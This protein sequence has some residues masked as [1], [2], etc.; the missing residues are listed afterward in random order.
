M[1]LRK[2]FCVLA[3]APVLLTGCGG[4]SGKDP[5]AWTDEVCGALAGFSTTVSS[6]PAVDQND[7]EAVKAGLSTFFASTSAALKEAI[8]GL[9]AAG[10]APVKGGDEYVTRLTETLT[11]IDTSFTATSG[12]IGQ[13]D[14]SSPEAFATALTTELAPLQ[15][16]ENIADPTRGLED[17]QELGAAADKA[18]NCQKLRTG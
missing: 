17:A 15:E 16:L 11:R 5:V 13:I 3:V 14:T 6:P 7:P 8:R 18:P 12:R 10:P 4:S 1:M 9:K 2:V